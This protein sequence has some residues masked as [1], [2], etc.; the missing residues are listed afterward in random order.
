MIPKG[1]TM[2]SKNPL[3]PVLNPPADPDS[4]PGLSDSSPLY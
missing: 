1:N 2:T 3:N 4:Y